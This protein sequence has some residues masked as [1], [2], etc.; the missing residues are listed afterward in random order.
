MEDGRG[1]HADVIFFLTKSLAYPASSARQMVH[2]DSLRH[3]RMRVRN[4]E[5]TGLLMCKAWRPGFRLSAF[6]SSSRARRRSMSEWSTATRLMERF[7]GPSRRC[8]CAEESLP[9]MVER[10]PGESGHGSSLGVRTSTG[11]DPE[12]VRL[13]PLAACH[14]R[15]RAVRVVPLHSQRT[16]RGVAPRAGQLDGVKRHFC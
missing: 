8:Q 4:E 9:G 14:S 2:L 13:R 7:T 15:I 10:W 16:V 5:P 3:S 6:A 12:E 1:T 11:T